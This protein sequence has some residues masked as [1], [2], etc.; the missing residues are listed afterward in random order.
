MLMRSDCPVCRS[1][2]L[3]PKARVLLTSGDRSVLATLFQIDDHWLNACEAGLS[4]SAWRRLGVNEGDAVLVRH[5][6]RVES[7]ADVRRRIHGHRLH[8]RAFLAII[9]D[10][11]AG[12]YLDIDLATFI[13]ACSALPLD[14]DEM[15]HLTRAMVDTGERLHW[16]VP[17]VIDKH[18]VG[19]LPGNRTTPIVVAIVAAL[20]LVMPKTSS[21]AITSPA[22]T[23]DVMETLAPVDLDLSL[24]RHVVET[25]GGCLAWGGNVRLSPAD[26]ILIRIERALD[27]D[28]EG[29]MVASILSKKIAAGSTHVIIDMPVG[30]TAKVRTGA[31]A[32]SL[33]D[34]LEVV[35]EAFGLKLHCIMTD[36]SQP[37]GRGIGPALEARDVLL[38]LKNAAD[39]PQDLRERALLLAGAALEL[40][41]AA[42]KGEGS[43]IAAAALADGR[44][45]EKFQRICAAQG[46]MR[47]PPRAALTRVWRTHVA[48]TIDRFDNRR[49]S[50]L[51]KLAGAPDDMA[52]GLD[53]HVRRGDRVEAGAPLLTIHAESPGNLDYAFDYLAA[54]AGMI[55]MKG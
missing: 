24:I 40:A 7:L 16:D 23:A 42:A 5:P 20:G 21:R 48:G 28:T 4:E 2:G 37:V 17:I 53:L 41:G 45:W 6:P 3:A 33:A 15:T 9:A 30:R 12:R 11:V 25:E 35:A 18:C 44:A 26:D 8:A 54:N 36:G 38:V 13:T 49:I 14:R 52:A 51:A 1:E 10:I 39:A 31:A 19:G 50:R 55:G 29:Q 34:H 27:I 32:R 47:V 46:G 43:D 22:G